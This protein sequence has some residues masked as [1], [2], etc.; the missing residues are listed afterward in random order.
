M[1]AGLG[2]H[3]RRGSAGPHG[4]VLEAE[5]SPGGDPLGTGGGG[6]GSVRKGCVSPEARSLGSLFQKRCVSSTPASKGG[7]RPGGQPPPAP[8]PVPFAASAAGAPHP[9]LSHV[10]TYSLRPTASLHMP[11][12][13]SPSTGKSGSLALA[14]WSWTSWATLGESLSLS[15]PE[16]PHV[17]NGG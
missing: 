8:R 9:G 3:A 15:G 12:P 2:E 16:F 14:P 5:C 7:A 1:S 10:F 6:C 4:E 13:L 17:C 11:F